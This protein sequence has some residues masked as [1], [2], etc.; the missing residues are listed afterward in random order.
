MNCAEFIDILKSGQPIILR[1]YSKEYVRLSENSLS[2]VTGT[3]EHIC[4]WLAANRKFKRILSAGTVVD[5]VISK[6][7]L[8]ELV[9]F[10]NRWQEMRQARRWS[11]RNFP[12]LHEIAA[13][14]Y[15]TLTPE[16]WQIYL[17]IGEEAVPLVEHGD[18]H[19]DLGAYEG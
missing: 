5:F 13:F 16:Y 11:P 17:A 19:T 6:K 18:L 15:L 4:L 8:Q 2:I 14:V 7:N 9:W 3:G 1:R 12:G 10:L